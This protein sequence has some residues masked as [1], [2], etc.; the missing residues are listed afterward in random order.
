MEKKLESHL[1]VCHST[2]RR[3]QTLILW[4]KQKV[5]IVLSF[6]FWVDAF[7]LR[8]YFVE[9][10]LFHI[11]VFDWGKQKML[12]WAFLANSGLQWTLHF[13]HPQGHWGWIIFN[14]FLKIVYL[15]KNC[16]LIYCVVC[17]K[18]KDPLTI[19]QR[20]FYSSNTVWV[21]TEIYNGF[22]DFNGLDILQAFTVIKLFDYTIGIS[23]SFTFTINEEVGRLMV[24]LENNYLTI[25][26]FISFYNCTFFFVVHIQCQ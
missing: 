25:K 10:A 14:V 13:A 9:S 7:I 26:Y 24:L 5:I 18:R 6:N 3:K 16:H 21:Y 22:G 1:A 20:H 19:Y 23:I 11:C 4:K 8:V 15:H 17:E 12:L 2:L